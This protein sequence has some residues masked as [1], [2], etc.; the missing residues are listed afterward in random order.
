MDF[1]KM[2]TVD[3]SYTTGN[4]LDLIFGKYTGFPPSQE[5]GLIINPFIERHNN[6]TSCQ[7]TGRIKYDTGVLVQVVY[8]PSFLL[9]ILSS[10]FLIYSILTLL[11]PLLK[12]YFSVLFY[13]GCQLFLALCLI[14]SLISSR[15]ISESVEVC[16]V[17]EPL[18]SVGIILP[19][20]AVL[21]I[22][23][24]RYLFLRYPMEWRNVLTMPRQ[25]TGQWRV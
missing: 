22:T 15:I 16:K 19:G 20:Y 14:F 7:P 10:M 6:G 9:L 3:P 4:P 5:I 11:R 23:V 2:T 17:T 12:I 1:K 18:Q 13:A 8:I 24:V 25:I 21:G